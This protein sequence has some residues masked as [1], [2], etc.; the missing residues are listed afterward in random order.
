MADDAHEE[1]PL[2]G[3]SAPAQVP[4]TTILCILAN[5]LC[6][7][8]AYFAIATNVVVSKYF[9]GH[10]G[11]PERETSIKGLINRVAE[12]KSLKRLGSVPVIHTCPPVSASRSNKAA[13][14]S[15]SRCGVTRLN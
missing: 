1:E 12:T 10:M 8:I 13:R 5:E 2:L 14:R 15:G 9:R 3:G 11:T 4:R 6:E 7:R